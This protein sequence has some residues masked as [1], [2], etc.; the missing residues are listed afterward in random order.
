MSPSTFASAQ[1]NLPSG[2]AIAKP[3]ERA[4][5]RLQAAAEVV[6][7]EDGLVALDLHLL[8][9]GAAVFDRL[10]VG[11][12][13][14]GQGEPAA[15][16]LLVLWGWMSLA[17]PMSLATAIAPV[18]DGAGGQVLGLAQARPTATRR[19]GGSRP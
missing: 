3:A 2:P 17:S 1:T 15:D 4:A 7:V 10:A 19:A 14:G 16:L 8:E 5:L 13:A 12:A 6:E 11:D 18:T 9:G